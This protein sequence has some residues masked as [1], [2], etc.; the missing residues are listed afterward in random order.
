MRSAC[1][2]RRPDRAFTAGAGLATV[3]GM[4]VE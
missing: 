2:Q 3:I 4:G 1:F